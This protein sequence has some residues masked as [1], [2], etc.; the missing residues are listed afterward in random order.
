MTEMFNAQIELRAGEGRRLTAPLTRDLTLFGTATFQLLNA[1]LSPAPVYS[2]AQNAA[3][4]KT[5]AEAEA[6]YFDFDSTGLAPAVY[7]VGRFVYQPKPVLGNDSE[8]HV[9][10]WQVQIVICAGP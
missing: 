5:L 4:D 6:V 8:A 1:D 9:Y 7:Y 10:F 2:T 3:Y